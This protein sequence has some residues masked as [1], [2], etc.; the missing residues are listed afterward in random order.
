MVSPYGRKENSKIKGI[1]C[2]RRSGNDVSRPGQERSSDGGLLQAGEET[3]CAGHLF[4]RGYISFYDF[5]LI[6]ERES[7][8]AQKIESGIQRVRELARL[9]DMWCVVGTITPKVGRWSNDAYLITPTGKIRGVYTKI[10]TLDG[11]RRLVAQG[12]ALPT[13]KI[14]DARVG[15]QICNDQNIPK[16]G[17]FWQRRIAMSFF[18]RCLETEVGS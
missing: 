11:E 15:I 12:E 7:A 9:Y 4:P 5:A 17:R 2:R 1:A 13:F 6:R 16:S 14:I 10:F 3:E 8:Y 18:I